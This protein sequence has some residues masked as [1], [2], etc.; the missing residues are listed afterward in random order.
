[1]DRRHEFRV[2][3]ADRQGAAAR[4]GAAMA[5][6]RLDLSE[7]DDRLA[8]AYQAVTYGELDRLVAD[9]PP[10]D[11]TRTA[12]PGPGL[13]AI[14]SRA[15]FPALPMTLKVLWAAWLVA[16]TASLLVWL[17]LSLR[18]G[19]ATVFWPLAVAMAGAPLPGV[20]VGVVVARRGAPRT[21]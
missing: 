15:G 6:G 13:A 3:D 5:E 21:L 9:L 14:R 12:D 4:L 2:S 19:D 16:S 11:P 10:R 20:T 1:M 7:Y 17:G 8:R 18:T